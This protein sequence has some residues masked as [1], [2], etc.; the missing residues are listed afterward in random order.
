MV[1]RN[2]TIVE[3]ARAKAKALVEREAVRTGSRMAGYEA[4]A[5]MIGRS[6]EWLRAFVNDYGNGKLDPT[7]MNIDQ[8]YQ[9]ITGKQ[10]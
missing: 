4:V 10:D 2:L 6:P 8:Q 1:V 7:I 9:R 5:Q 3:D